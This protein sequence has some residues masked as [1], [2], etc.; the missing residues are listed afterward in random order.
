[1]G[2]TK[3]LPSILAPI[4]DSLRSFAITAYHGGIAQDF[5]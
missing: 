2:D 5:D 3:V 1:M 4:S